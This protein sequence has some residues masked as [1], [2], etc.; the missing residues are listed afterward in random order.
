[1]T[2]LD[3]CLL[4]T[5]GGF[6]LAGIWFGLVHMVGAF[7]GMFLGIWAAGVYQGAIADWL[8]NSFGWN[9]NL[10]HVLAF[11]FIYAL[12]AR[13]AGVA[14]WFVEKI[15][16]FF[17]I[18]PFLKTFDRLLGAALGFLEGMIAVGL[19]IYFAARFPWNDSFAAAL[20]ASTYAPKFLAVGSTLAPLLPAAI[21]ALKAV[22]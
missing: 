15:F 17:T 4:I 22:I 18:I 1:M 6:V 10:S 13:L 7:V 5:L 11:M 12:V 3:L 2:L 9:A 20:A 19:F 16:G 21:R 8:V 14:L